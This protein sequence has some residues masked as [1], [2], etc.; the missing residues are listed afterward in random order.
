MFRVASLSAPPRV[1]VPVAVAVPLATAGER[2]LEH[3]FVD[4]MDSGF[5]AHAVELLGERR[6]EQ[7]RE[8]PAQ[9]LLAGDAGELL[10]L[11]IPALHAIFQVGR[12]NSHVD[13]LDDVLAEFLQPLVLLHLALQRT[14]ERGVFDGDGDVAGQRDQQFH[15]HAG[16]V[17]AVRSVRLSADVGDGAAADR[18]RQIVGQIQI[19]DGLAHRDRPGARYGV[20]L[21]ARALEKQVRFRQF[22]VQE[23]E[24][25]IVRA[26]RR[27]GADWGPSPSCRRNAVPSS[28]S[29]GEEKRQVL[30]AQGLQQP[31]ADRWPAWCRDRFP[32]S[33]P[34][35]TPPGCGGS[36][37]G[38]GRNAGPAA[39][40]SS[41]G[42]AGRGTP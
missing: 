14:V 42:W 32:N 18:A 33:A 27:P 15:V 24:V 13:R 23:A 16:E 34:G 36:R 2:R 25:Q 21:M 6:R 17:I 22:P 31:V 5:A 30:D 3:E 41:C 26:R 37:S 4:V 38:R 7:L 10:D 40:A 8:L 1:S 35:R 11:R 20:Q 19:R 12:Q 29:C 9:R 28:V 39:P